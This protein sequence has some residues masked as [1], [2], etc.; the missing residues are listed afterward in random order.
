MGYFVPSFVE[1]IF[2]YKKCDVAVTLCNISTSTLLLGKGCPSHQEY[3]RL[4]FVRVSCLTVMGMGRLCIQISQ[5]LK[6]LNNSSKMKSPKVN[7]C[8]WF[9]FLKAPENISGPQIYIHNVQYQKF[10]FQ[11][12]FET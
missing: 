5:K 4:Y 6:T 12:D 3:K 1:L 10:E 2:L 9:A 8:F 11:F 7:F